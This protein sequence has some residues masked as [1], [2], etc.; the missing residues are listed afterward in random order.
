MKVIPTYGLPGGA[1]NV[2]RIA[3]LNARKLSGKKAYDKYV[4]L[5]NSFGGDYLAAYQAGEAARKL[6]KNDDAKSWYDKALTINTEYKPAQAAR[7]K[8]G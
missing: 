6:K 5:A 7:K 8:L 2:L 3:H 1:A 4:E